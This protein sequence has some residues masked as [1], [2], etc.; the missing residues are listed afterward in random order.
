MLQEGIQNEKE[1]TVTQERTAKAMG[2]GELPVFA[3]PAMAA[4]MEQTAWE[5]VASELEEGCGTVGTAL[6]LKHVS[7]TPVGMRVCCESRLVKVEGRALTFALKA[8]DE[9]GLIGEAV[10]QRFIVQNERFLAKAKKKAK[11][12]DNEGED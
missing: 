12:E 1:L 5:S 2:S 6:D 7:A 9:K 4:L 11:P 8:Y 10:H 3:T